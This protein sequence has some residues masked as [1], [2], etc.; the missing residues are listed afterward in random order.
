[1]SSN[2][3]HKLISVV[4]PVYNGGEYLNEAIESVLHQTYTNFEFL[5]ID[6]GSKDRSLEIIQRYAAIDQRIK[7]I[8][9]E[10]KGLVATLNEGIAL[11]KGDYIARMDA[12]DVSLPERFVRQIMALEQTQADICGCHALMIDAS[13]KSIRSLMYPVLPDMFAF[14]MLFTTPF[15]HG[16]VMFRRQKYVNDALSY[17]LNP[18]YQ[19]VED[20]ALWIEMYQRGYQFISVDEVLFKYRYLATSFSRT[21]LQQMHLDTKAITKAFFQAYRMD[22]KK[23]FIKLK[24]LDNLN[25]GEKKILMKYAF[26]KNELGYILNIKHWRDILTY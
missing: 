19:S 1:M 9:R 24:T 22:L 17:G 20:L 13:G 12:D 16:S 8:S 11:A 14:Y 6:D 21:K 26:K 10:N 18:S 3:M 5:I 2:D 25:A 23:Q 15:C 4:M 7:V